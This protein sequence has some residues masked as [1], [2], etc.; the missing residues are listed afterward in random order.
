MYEKRYAMLMVWP[1]VF[2]IVE[3][4]RNKTSW[5][6]SDDLTESEARVEWQKLSHTLKEANDRIQQ[7]RDNPV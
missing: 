5:D 3:I 1:D 4:D 7:A 6:T 2:R